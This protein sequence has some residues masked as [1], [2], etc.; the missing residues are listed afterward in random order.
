MSIELTIVTPQGIVYQG[1]VE[2]VVLPGTEGEFGVLEN[3]ERFLAP[4][5][6][7]EVE[8]QTREGSTFAA[9]ADGFAD[10][11]GEEV[12]VLVESCEVAGDIDVARA[13][14]ARERASRAWHSSTGTRTANASRNSK[15]RSSG[16]EPPR[17][18]QSRQGLARRLARPPREALSFALPSS[19]TTR[20]R[21]SASP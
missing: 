8:I 15:P 7:G 2:S 5:R 6:I 1:P 21:N 4:L 3:H 11:D 13:E 17:G 14:L 16:R 19:T 10:V 9:I 12:T 20:K 18:E